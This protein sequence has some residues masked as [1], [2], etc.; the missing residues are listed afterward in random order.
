M[1]NVTLH[2][3]GGWNGVNLIGFFSFFIIG[4]L[5]RLT[6]AD[7]SDIQKQGYEYIRCVDLCAQYL[8]LMLL[9]TLG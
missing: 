9:V 8:V 4:I 3:C 6:E 1:L 7:Q 2:V 5:A